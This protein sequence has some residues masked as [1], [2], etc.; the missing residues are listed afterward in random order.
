MTFIPAVQV[1]MQNPYPF[2]TVFNHTVSQ[3]VTVVCEVL[4]LGLLIEINDF[5][6]FLFQ[7][8]CKALTLN[9]VLVIA[10]NKLSY[11]VASP[12][13]SSGELFS[14]SLSQETRGFMFL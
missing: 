5:F 3:R 1:Q 10:K 12:P 2:Y 9:A 7:A 13:N 14:R 4:Y 6:F 8:G 11:P